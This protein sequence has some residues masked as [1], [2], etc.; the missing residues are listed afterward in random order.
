M[1]A[2]SKFF[3]AVLSAMIFMAIVP[4][5]VVALLGTLIYGTSLT[6]IVWLL[7]CSRGVDTLV[8]YSESPHWQQYMTESVIPNLRGRAVVLNWSQRR[9]WRLLSLRGAVFKFFGGD[10]EFNPLVVVF[11]PFRIPQTFRF[12]KPFRDRKHGN[13]NPLRE[14][15]GKLYAYLKTTPSSAG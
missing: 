7:W 5:V 9:N 3:S 2:I 10:R 1:S 14:L 6:M 4:F 12:W 8:V 11:R 13:L 15:E